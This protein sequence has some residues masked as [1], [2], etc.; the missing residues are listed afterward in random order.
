MLRPLLGRDVGDV[1]AVEPHD[2]ALGDLEPADD[3]QDRRLARAVRAEQRDALAAV[4]LEVHVEQHLHRCRTRSRCSRPAAPACRAPSSARLRCSSCS[5]SSSST[6]SDRSLRMNRAPF[7]SSRPPMMLVGIAEDEHGAAHADRV[8]EE[9][10]EDRRRAKPPMKH[11]VHD[12]HR[13]AQAA[14]PV[15]AH[16]LQHRRD[17]RERARGEHGLRDAPD[18]EP[19]PCCASRTAAA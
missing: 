11:D 17:H 9:V 13:D 1:A 19:R 10:G 8:G 16:R 2:A 15:R 6:T 12:A 5:S 4:D 3:A 18:D 7:I 14:Q